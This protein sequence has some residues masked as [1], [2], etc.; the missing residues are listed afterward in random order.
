MSTGPAYWTAFPFRNL[1]VWLDGTQ[2]ED[3]SAYPMTDL[4]VIGGSR[5]L[6]TV[7]GTE[8]VQRRWLGSKAPVNVRS[9]PIRL[10]MNVKN[11]ADYRLFLT[12][13]QRGLAVELYP[14]WPLIEEW[15]IPAA[16]ANQTTWE[17]ARK[18]PWD[19][20]G[21]DHTTRPPRVY[22]DDV[23]Q[24]IVTTGTPGA[25]E[26]KVPIVGD[27]DYVTTPTGITGTW[28]RLEYHPVLTVLITEVGMAYSEFNRLVFQ[29]DA[30]EQM[31]RRFT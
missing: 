30:I 18:F 22:K 23:S 21:I 27:F 16:A 2:I 31:A 29:V 8:I 15:Y 4:S 6:T 5:M 12:K 14:D 19:L 1:G 7:G 17:P 3:G 10:Q 24:T 9:T 20:S 25:G 28:L 13:A 11:E 26:A